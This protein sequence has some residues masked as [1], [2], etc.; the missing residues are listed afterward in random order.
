MT[1]PAVNF[2]S[3]SGPTWSPMPVLPVTVTSTGDH[4]ANNVVVHGVGV[5][6]VPSTTCSSLAPGQAC[7]ANIQFCPSA[8]GSYPATLV[9]TGNDAVTGAALQ[10][11]TQL[12]GQGNSTPRCGSSE[13]RPAVSRLG[14]PRLEG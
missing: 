9:V 14:C 1:L 11:T 4:I 7:T 5:Y 2:P 3:V 8:T 12:S 13:S 10:G 6:S